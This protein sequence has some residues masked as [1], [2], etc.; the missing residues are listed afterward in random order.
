MGPIALVRAIAGA[1]FLTS[2]QEKRAATPIVP[3]VIPEEKGSGPGEGNP[4][5]KAELHSD[6]LALHG[7]GRTLDLFQEAAELPVLESTGSELPPR[8]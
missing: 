2:R 3:E 6:S 5:D 4:Q 7:L 8:F 1:A